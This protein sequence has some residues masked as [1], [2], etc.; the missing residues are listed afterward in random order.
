[1]AVKSR[2]KSK[3]KNTKKTE[4]KPGILI[5]AIAAVLV[6]AVIV[7]SVVITKTYKR[8]P[9]TVY[10]FGKEM[11]QGIDV[12]EHNGDIDWNSVA[13][14][15][16]FAFIRVG[17]RGYGNGT[18]YEDKTAKKNMKA[19][20]RAGIP[21]GVYFYTQAVNEDEAEEEADFVMNIIKHYD[22][23]LPVMI[24]FE[25]PADD[26]GYHTGRLADSNLSAEENTA[27]VNAF[28]DRVRKKGYIAGIY[29]SS[30]VFYYNFNA[31]D[32]DRDTV[33]WTADYNDNVT[34]KIDY[35]IWQYSR[36]GQADSVSSKY[37]DLNYWYSEQ[38][39][40]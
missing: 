17:Y 34:F 3:Q 2:K 24:D 39:K 13:D 5:G 33:L 16:D 20:Q 36:T 28:C 30:S 4:L 14:E 27:V 12:S 29:A 31:K 32:I 35:D 38:Q 6:I 37:V 15:F 11:A 23:S 1:M 25:Y 18:V 26:N 7:S 10:D 9:Q 19:A 8:T 22:L 40:G 21:F